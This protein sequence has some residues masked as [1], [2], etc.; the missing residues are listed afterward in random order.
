LRTTLPK[1]E[2]AK[3]QGTPS[4]HCSQAEA[5]SN[6]GRGERGRSTHVRGRRPT[7]HQPPEDPT[8]TTT[9]GIKYNDAIK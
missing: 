2:E 7:D 1:E 6:D 4:T 3:E 5:R 8:I 9:G